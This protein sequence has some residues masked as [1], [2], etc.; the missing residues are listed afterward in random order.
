MSGVILSVLAEG[1]KMVNGSFKH[2]EIASS[3]LAGL[4][5]AFGGYKMYEFE[6][7]ADDLTEKKCDSYKLNRFR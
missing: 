3:C 4:S 2:V 1:V 6:D 7:S 5:F